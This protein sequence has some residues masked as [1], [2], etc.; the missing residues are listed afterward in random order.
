MEC[1]I[2]LKNRPKFIDA[3]EKFQLSWAYPVL[4]AILCTISGVGNKYVYLPVISVLAIPVLFSVL[5]VRDKMVVFAPAI[6]IYFSMGIDSH[7]AFAE[8]RGEVASSFDT[9]GLIG[10]CILGII[11]IAP[12][13][14]RIILD[15]SFARVFK[16]KNPL[17]Y[18]IIF[19][20]VATLLGGLLSEHWTPQSFLYGIFVVAG[21]DLFFI[22]LSSVIMDSKALTATY[23]CRALVLTCLMIC[24]QI[25]ILALYLQAN[26]MLIRIK[27]WSGE[28]ILL[29]ENLAMSWGISTV[30]GATAVLGIPAAMYLAKNERFPIIYYISAL[31]MF[32]TSVLVNA[33]SAMLVGGLFLL[34]GIIAA[35]F[36]GKNKR[37]NLIFSICLLFV[38]ACGVAAALCYLAADS[39]IAEL[40]SRMSKFMRFDSVDDRLQ[41]YK[42]G[43]DDF[44]SSPILGVGWSKGGNSLDKYAG[45]FYSNM[46]H[47]IV[48]QMAASTGIVGIWAMLFHVKDLVV[49]ACKNFKLDRLFLLS[50]PAMILAMSLVD[51]FFF[52]LN[53]QIIYIAFLLVAQKFFNST[54]NKTV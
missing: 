50:V 44:I 41:L 7:G 17:S 2:R 40:W 24:A 48:I 23:A 33:R 54:K 35:S 1:L 36:F 28:W 15:G 37:C 22:I 11:V 32:G 19:L 43:L 30:I 39:S 16:E 46:Y 53:F 21:L 27:E 4:F 13:L 52:Y 26:G 8:T 42:V 45:N 51:N 47:C 20:N 3:I 6:M 38:A 34:L 14:L 9:D 29:R 10:I 12:F 49:M 5:F 25:F 18:G 31:I